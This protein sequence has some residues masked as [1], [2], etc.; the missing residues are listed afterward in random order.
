[1]KTIAE[2]FASEGLKPGSWTTGIGSLP[3][4]NVDAAL[5]Y[6]FRHRIPFL[7]QIPARN[8]WEYLLPQALEH[9]P[10][11]SVETDGSAK[12]D[13]AIWAHQAFRLGER[14]NRAFDLSSSDPEAFFAFEPTAPVASSWQPFLWEC[15][16]RQT[17]IAKIQIAG[18]L[19]CQWVLK[20]QNDP[21][22]GSL[23]FKLVLAR[24]LAMTRRLAQT[25][26][27]PLF[28][29]DE[30]ALYLLQPTQPTHLQALVELKVLVQTLQ[31]EGAWVGIHCC[32]D[33]SWGSVLG[34]GIDVLSFDWELSA[35][36]FAKNTSP[37]QIEALYSR[38]GSLSLG[39]VP[40]GRE[41]WTHAFH[42]QAR[43]REIAEWAARDTRLLQLARRSLLTPA[44]GLALSRLE[45]TEM[46]LDQLSETAH[47]LQEGLS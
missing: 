42:P 35:D 21:E 13:H 24:S 8:P 26:A 4:A 9:L 47:H 22:L 23:I 6:S 27:K 39:V 46:V 38:G 7:P 45:T 44:C 16:E 12:L 18:P 2:A 31:R 19:T 14:L 41:G 28:F 10:G 17:Q 5:E 20:Q 29:L 11:L 1:M 33:T 37:D 40:T 3:H 25:G 36:S 32:S 30:P 34:L 43:A 15:T